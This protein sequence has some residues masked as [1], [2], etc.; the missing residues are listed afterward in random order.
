MLTHLQRLL[1]HLKEA[2]FY[3]PK[4]LDGLSSQMKECRLYVE[5]GSDAYS[6]HLLTLLDARIKVCEETLA[7]LRLNLTHLTP[8]LTPKWEKLVSLLRSLAGCNARSKF[9]N[10][11]VDAYAKEL[12]ELE[13]ELKK[14]GIVAYETTGS[15]E[16]KLIEMTE[17]MQLTA[18]NPE[19]AP[20]AETLISQLLRRNLLWVA[21]IKEKSA[22]RPY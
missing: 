7:T 18:A 21:L 2:M 14:D 12:Y 22:I 15:T 9:P 11:E 10:E 3:S 4:D 20:E 6:P 16:D 13:E 1:D 8:E 19:P 5:R 17:K